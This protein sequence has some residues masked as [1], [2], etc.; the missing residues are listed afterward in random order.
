MTKEFLLY[1]STGFVGDVMVQYAVQK[2]LKPILAGRNPEKLEQQSKK[3][4]L[5]YFA[6][7]L[8]HPKLM[9]AA[10]RET[11]LVLN[12]AGPFLHTARAMVAGCLRMK[13]HY[14]DISGEIPVYEWISG[15]ENEAINLNVMLLPGVGFDVGPTDCLAFHLKNRLPDADRLS[16]AFH[17]DGPAGLPPGTQRT[18]IELLPFGNC[19]RNNGHL[20]VAPRGLITRMVDFGFGPIEVTRLTWGDLFTAYKSTGIPNIENYMVFS[21][22]LRQQVSVLNFIQPITRYPLVRKMMMLNVKP[23]S[24]DNQRDL[25]STHVWGEAAN[26]HGNRVVSRLH[27][28][29]ASVDWT[30]QTAIAAVEKV[31]DGQ[32]TPGFQTPALA[33]GPD[34][35]L[36]NEKVT[37]EDL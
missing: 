16:L 10:L 14:L 6:F 2:G 25:T 23:G 9:D 8:D 37:R 4:D 19:I 3:Y 36:E 21:K 30:V 11:D 17:S 26:R 18:M 13:R 24:P 22:A 15:Q 32:F 20:Q 12:C 5:P 31:L 35:V 29:E 1:G 7:Q 33:F 34:F 28:P 27:G